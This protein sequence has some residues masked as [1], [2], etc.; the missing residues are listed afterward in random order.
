MPRGK[1]SQSEH[2]RAKRP[3]PDE[4]F[5]P[6]PSPRR[7]TDQ[8]VLALREEGRSFSAIARQL[9]LRRAK[10]AYATFH[11][12][13]ASR[14]EAERAEIVRR[15]L[16][17]LAVLEVRIRS[18]DAKEPEKMARRLEGLEQMRQNLH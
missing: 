13:L 6:P 18:R 14:P 10:D 2:G 16:E 11:R 12:T 8:V 1:G 3:L 9:G 17:R 4:S 5:R 7:N 15:E